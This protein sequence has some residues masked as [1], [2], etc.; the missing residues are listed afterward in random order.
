MS[1]KWSGPVAA[2]LAH[3]RLDKGVSEKTLLAYGSDLEQWLAFLGKRAPAEASADELRAFLGKL[4]RA[5]MG[6]ASQ[7]RKL[8]SL[9]VFHAWLIRENG[10]QTDPTASV[11]A[12]R[13]RRQ[14]PSTL[15]KT[16]VEKIFSKVPGK[17]EAGVRDRAMLELLYGC[18]LRISEL[19]A[20]T[21]LC[22]RKEE[23]LIRVRGKGGKERLVPYG[24]GAERWLEAYLAIYPRMNPGFASP[25][26][27]PKISR[28]A[29]WKKLRE[30]A[31]AAGLSGKVSPHS[32]RHSFATHLLEGGMNLRSVQTLL[33][34]SDISTTQIYT[35][36]EEERLLEAHHRFHPRK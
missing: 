21:P 20:L 31:A 23:K 6:E 4:R 34:H 30:W 27:F 15:T 10:A 9:R 14:L 3:L 19:L 32:L 26:L 16:E 18:G 28:Q 12:P 2:F 7:R 13:V 33:G 22:L 5:G 11:E 29:F 25:L 36:V 8:S 35:H 17:D 24:A 1:R